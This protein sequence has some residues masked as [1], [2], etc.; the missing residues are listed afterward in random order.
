MIDPASAGTL[1]LGTATALL[2]LLI[3]GVEVLTRKGA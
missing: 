1:L 3:A 2:G